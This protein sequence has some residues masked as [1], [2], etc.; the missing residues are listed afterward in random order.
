MTIIPLI[1]DVMVELEVKPSQIVGTLN[2][3]LSKTVLVFFF[4][5]VIRKNS[6]RELE[7]KG[8]NK[9]NS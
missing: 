8:N 5:E 3:A 1:L 7:I 6:N 2:K 9:K 4:T